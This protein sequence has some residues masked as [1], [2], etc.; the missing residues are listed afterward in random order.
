MVDDEWQRI[1]ES[2]HEAANDFGKAEFPAQTRRVIYRLQRIPTSGIFGEDYIY[3]TLWDEFCHEAQDGP[4]DLLAGAWKHTMDAVVNEVI[5]RLPRHVASLLSVFAD[6]ELGEQGDST[7]VG[8][9]WLDGMNRVVRRQL[10]EQA[11]KRNLDRLGPWRE[12]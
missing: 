12:M 7:L 2:T 3:K 5:E 8:S 11:G 6:S 9:V 1:L 10:C 4:H